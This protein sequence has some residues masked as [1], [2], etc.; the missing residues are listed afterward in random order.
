MIA[1]GTPAPAGRRVDAVFGV[2]G[3]LGLAAAPTFAGMALFT[4]LSGGDG[5]MICSAPAMSPLGGMAP[6][7]LLMSIFHSTH[8]FR[9][10]ARR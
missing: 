6:M 2:A 3:W 1:A 7:Y 9:L 8:W 4:Y 10:L 5:A